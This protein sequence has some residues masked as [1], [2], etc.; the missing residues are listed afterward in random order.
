MKAG[1]IRVKSA[2]ERY[3]QTKSA[4]V[5]PTRSGRTGMGAFNPLGGQEAVIEG[6]KLYHPSELDNAIAKAYFK[7]CLAK[8]VN[9]GQLPENYRMNDHE[10][11]LMNYALNECEWTGMIKGRDSDTGGIEVNRKKLSG[12]QVKALLDDSVSGGIEA[13]PVAFDDAII[14]IPILYGELFPHVDVQNVSR[15]RRMKGAA[16]QNPGFSSGYAEGTAIQPFNTSSFVS[17]FDTPIFPAVSAMEIG[18]DFE[19]DSPI[20]FQNNITEQYGLKALEWL[21]RVIAVGDGVTEPEGIFTATGTTSV[22]SDNGPGGRATISDYEG[23]L[24]GLAKQFRNEPGAVCCYVANDTMYRRSRA[25]DVGPGDERRLFGMTHSDY[26]IMERP[27]K[28]QNDIPN[29]WIAHVNLKRYRMY[30]R[31]G[32]NIRVET[33]GRSLALTNTKLIVLRMRYGGRLTLGGACAVMLDA[34]A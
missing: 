4:A 25:I 10:K 15:G 21:D 17:A 16:M 18:L 33:A 2:A 23:L 7:M 1:H 26:T 9:Q 3:A 6:H 27:Y 19:E 13:A 28:V 11:D 32:L 14:L 8:S 30:R 22:T 31:L 12:M 34:A 5:Y 24:F 29:G 20:N